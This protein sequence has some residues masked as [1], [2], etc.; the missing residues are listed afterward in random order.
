MIHID[1]VTC[2]GS[3]IN[4]TVLKLFQWSYRVW[5][6][7]CCSSLLAQNK[8]YFPIFIYHSVRRFSLLSKRGKA[9]RKIIFSRHWLRPSLSYCSP[10]HFLG[11]QWYT[12][13]CW[14]LSLKSSSGLLKL[15][16][17]SKA[18]MFHRHWSVIISK[19]SNSP[20]GGEH[21]FTLIDYKLTRFQEISTKLLTHFALLCSARTIQLSLN[22]PSF[23]CVFL[24]QKSLLDVYH[25]K[26]S[27]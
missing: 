14:Q 23:S 21:A 11:L 24:L 25:H 8:N 5:Q 6:R 1:M 2:W 26:S 4:Q 16:F 13:C 12:K 7:N 27:Q 19:T 9:S 18:S 3:S 15:D 22:P 17:W 10:Q 20:R